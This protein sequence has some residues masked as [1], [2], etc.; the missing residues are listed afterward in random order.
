M[1]PEPVSRPLR[2]NAGPILPHLPLIRSS[3]QH[4]HPRH[5]IPASNTGIGI[6]A[7]RWGS[8][9]GMEGGSGTTRGPWFAAI[10][11]V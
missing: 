4:G 11:E 3:E 5:S 10:G 1:S 9:A 6:H 7:G 2:S 8:R